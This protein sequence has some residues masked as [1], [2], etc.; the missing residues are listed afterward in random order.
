VRDVHK[1]RSLDLVGWFTLM[2]SSGPASNVLAIHQ[3]VLEHFN[4][5]AVLLGFSPSELLQARTGGK[6]PIAIYE[7]NYEVDSSVDPQQESDTTMESPPLQQNQR[8]QQLRLKFRE[9]PYAVEA[10]EAEMISMTHVTQHSSHAT[11]TSTDEKPAEP[12][13]TTPLG[14]SETPENPSK[15]KSPV[16]V[17]A[18]VK[19]KRRA[20]AACDAPSSKSKDKSVD[21]ATTSKPIDPVLRQVEEE[22]I[23]TLTTRANAIKMLQARVQL[24]ATYLEALPEN[25]PSVDELM[26][27][28]PTSTT[29]SS[30]GAVSPDSPLAAAAP[31]VTASPV[32]LRQ[33]QALVTRLSLVVPDSLAFQSELDR[34]AADVQLI[35]RLATALDN[36][37]S[38]WDLGK[39]IV[40]AEQNRKGMMG[41]GS[42][43]P[44]AGD[45]TLDLGFADL[46]DR[47]AARRL[48]GSAVI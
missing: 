15:G 23:A 18:S 45:M 3:Q 35:S 20:V 44:L 21:A 42:D 17:E 19:T 6:L 16:P 11:A 4:E 47:K 43:E 38:A 1:D 13:V 36:L 12:V 30:G 39:M 46:R 40:I 8:P 29:N 22:T 26:P 48:S 25:S 28:A 5:S 31:G 10:G 37:S 34:E 9:L 2:P 41:G 27:D 7:S 33:I 14:K 32:I 24:L